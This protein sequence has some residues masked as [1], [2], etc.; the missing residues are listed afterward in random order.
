M[1]Y[2]CPGRQVGA[3]PHPRRG[4]GRRGWLGAEPARR[5]CI[6][7]AV[8][9]VAVGVAGVAATIS[10]SLPMSI[11]TRSPARR[12]ARFCVMTMCMGISLG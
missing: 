1:T 9:L 7:F 8:A 11:S 10:H 3:R 5:G 4:R 12:L 6:L 2:R